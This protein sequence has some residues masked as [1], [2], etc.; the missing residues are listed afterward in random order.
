MHSLAG[1]LNTDFRVPNCD[2]ETFIRATGHISGNNLQ[3]VKKAFLL[4]VFNVIFNN[5]DDHTK[6]FSYV[7]NAQRQWQLAPTYDLTFN[8]GPKGYHQMSVM[9]EAG[10]IP[11]SAIFALGNIV[12]LSQSEVQQIVERCTTVASQFSN[13][14]QQYFPEAIR[15]TTLTHV[16]KILD[17]NIKAML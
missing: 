11:K 7:L 3:E 13:L 17:R 1:Y 12:E 10:V 4:A 5:R 14:C 16:Q 6:N 2:Y 8:E 15:K 9:G